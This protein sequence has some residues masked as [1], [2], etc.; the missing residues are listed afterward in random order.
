[1][2]FWQQ[3]KS[4][5][6]YTNNNNNQIDSYGVD[7]SGFNTQ[8]E[9]Q[10]QNARINREKNLMTQMNNQGITTYPQ[11]STN[12]WGSS[13]DNNYGFG[14]SNIGNNIESMQQNTKSAF[15][16]PKYWESEKEG[17]NIYD[18][19]VRVEGNI[20]PQ[21]QNVLDYTTSAIKG[22][23]NLISNSG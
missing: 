17:K 3:Y 13:A 23:I 4:P 22:G 5:L 8:D 11:Y 19:V 10:Y 16:E 7:H 2:S 21:N 20:Q 6:G 1:M 15:I 18:N 12:F 9:L 14:T